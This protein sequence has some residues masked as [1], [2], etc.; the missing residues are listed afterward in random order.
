[1]GTARFPSQIKYIIGNEAS[2]RFSFYGMRAILVV[3]MTDVLMK[4]RADAKAIYH[5][6]NQGVYFL[7]LLGAFLADRVWGKYKTIFWLSLIYC[8]GHLTLAVWESEAGLYAGLALI[9][10]GAGGIKPCVSSFVGDQF[11]TKEQAPLIERV[12]SIFY[13]SINFG[14]FFSSLL[15]PWLLV[16]Y[17][18]SVAFGLPGILMALATLILWAGR[19][20]YVDVPPS[21]PNGPAGFVTVAWSALRA[22]SRS[23][24]NDQPQ[25]EGHWLDHARARHNAL[26]VSGAKTAWGIFKVFATV[27][28]FWALFDQQGSSW[29]L[30]AKQ[31]DPEFLG[32]RWEASQIQALNPILVL[33]LI[34]IF[35]GWVYPAFER[36]GLKMTPLRKMSMGMALASLSFVSIGMLQFALDH[37]T[38]LSVGWQFIPYLIVTISEVMVSI[39][40]LEFAYTQAPAHL[41][42]TMMS[43]WMLTIALGNFLVAIIAKLNVFSGVGEFFFFAALMA[44]VATVFMS[45]ARKYRPVESAQALEPSPA[46]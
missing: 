23:K 18:S 11:T 22:K 14:A 15:T 26:E 34:P 7:P 2:E 29:T 38:K 32:M 3:F 27:T 44:I 10:L 45:S 28:V 4:E 42:S 12:Y 20:Q 9:A 39:P 8:L 35:S 41:K 16:K 33:I 24:S 5:L 46:N 17:G 1:M 31:M 6:F 13:F 21:G 36:L 40:G 19:R 30:Q 37:G 25:F 43:F